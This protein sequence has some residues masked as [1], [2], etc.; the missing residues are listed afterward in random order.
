MG[1]E[2][3]FL[4][5]MD[6]LHSSRLSGK[7]LCLGIGM[8]VLLFKSYHKCLV[9]APKLYKVSR[10][11]STVSLVWLRSNGFWSSGPLIALMDF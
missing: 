5:S 1:M 3:S 9:A 7:G 4:G 6:L 11:L 8:G 2:R 10:E